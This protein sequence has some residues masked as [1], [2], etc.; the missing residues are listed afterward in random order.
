MQDDGFERGAV[1]PRDIN[2][3]LLYQRRAKG[4]TVAAVV[5][6]GDQKDLYPE[7]GEIRNEP[8]EKT[9]RFHGRGQSVIEI[10]RQKDGVRFLFFCLF[11]NPFQKIR[12][13]FQ[14][15]KLAH[16]YPEVQIGEMKKLHSVP[17]SFQ[18]TQIFFMFFR[19]AKRLARLADCLVMYP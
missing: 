18:R 2:A 19:H 11:E 10:A 8:A 3:A 17:L 4:H 14:K 16:P 9:H 15:R 5:V 13:I 1:L 6:A 7:I 12:L